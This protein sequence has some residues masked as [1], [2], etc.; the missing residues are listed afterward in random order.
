MVSVWCVSVDGRVWYFPHRAQSTPRTTNKQKPFSLLFGESLF[1]HFN[2]D[3]ISL[4][5]SQI[6]LSAL[7]KGTSPMI[8]NVYLY[9]HMQF[10]KH[11]FS[12]VLQEAVRSISEA[13][14]CSP[15][16]GSS[17]VQTIYSLIGRMAIV[18]WTFIASHVC[19]R[20]TP[21]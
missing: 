2:V 17:S 20:C 4:T 21:R 13:P 15:H 19:N 9:E 1:L 3:N 18:S 12:S 16:G 10:L 14:I 6:T 5:F 7:N 11:E 8:L